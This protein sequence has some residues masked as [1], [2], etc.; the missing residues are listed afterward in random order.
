MH[1]T[2]AV[3]PARPEEQADALHLLFREL[4]P[5]DREHRVGIAL[6]LLRSGELD[7][8]GLFVLNED[9]NL[10]GVLICLPVPGASALFWPPRSIVDAHAAE[11]ED[12]LLTHAIHWVRA[13]GAKLSQALLTA[14]EAHLVKPLERNGFRHVTRLWYLAT[15][16]NLPVTALASLSP[17]DYV[18]YDV[19]NP[20]VFHQTL[21]STYEGT[22][23]C[24]EISGIRTIEEIITGH[25][26]QG[27]FNPDHWW[28]A[29]EAGQPI[30]VLLTAEMPESGD[31]DVAYLGVAKEA[32]RRGF[33][34]DMMLKALSEAKAAGVHRVTLSVDARNA[35]ALHLYHHLGLVPYDRREVYLALWK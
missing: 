24:P 5:L 8:A 12:S 28:L 1:P 35:P 31:W 11:R 33:G 22:Q 9:G 17:L 23:D 14:D 32:R 7:P 26:A 34:R 16:L 19:D 2:S 15:D 3:R 27:R 20:S 18:P 4:P 10:T 21:L 29:L 30:G 25:R 13:G 6:S